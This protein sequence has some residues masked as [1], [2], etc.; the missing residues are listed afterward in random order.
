MQLYLSNSDLT[1]QRKPKG[2]NIVPI[3][4]TVAI[5]V[6]AI[7]QFGPKNN[8][9]TTDNTQ[10]SQAV[11]L[12]KDIELPIPQQD[13]SCTNYTSKTNSTLI[14]VSLNRKWNLIGPEFS[15]EDQQVGF[16][17]SID[18]SITGDSLVLQ[19]IVKEN[20]KSNYLNK[21]DNTNYNGSVNAS[22][23]DPGTY[24]LQ[25]VVMDKC[26]YLESQEYEFYVS[27]PVYVAWTTDWEG[28]PGGNYTYAMGKMENV[29]D[30]YGV[31][32][33]HMFNPRI[34]LPSFS[35]STRDTYVNWV[36]DQRD[37]HGAEI[38]LHLHMFYD[39]VEAAG[40]T[41]RTDPKW[42]DRELNGYNVPATAYTKDEYIKIANWAVDQFEANNLGTPKAYRAG[43][44]YANIET[45]QAV[46]TAGLEIDSS[47]RTE[48]IYRSE[49]ISNY[50][51]IPVVS[52]PYHPSIADPNTDKY[53]K[54]LELWEIPNNGGDSW[55]FPSSALKDRF[56]QNFVNK[57]PQTEHRMVVYVSHPHYS[58][59]EFPK[60]IPVIDYIA[61]YSYTSDNG[62][63]IFATLSEIK[64][65]WKQL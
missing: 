54:K 20:S 38:G 46:Q 30:Q 8:T 32:I 31:K 13:P 36:I 33:T 56:D 65:V 4:L 44:W 3:I 27:K 45:L 29:V 40:V 50:W 58:T 9:P 15:I 43:G 39:L 7:K 55:S 59:T 41:K 25:V 48:Y 53:T 22:T 10:T 5:I 49:G 19:Y 62:P 47:G 21:I 17:T 16:S 51:S 12:D 2:N 34:F 52:T 63:V 11:V 14:N 28:L 37:N 1:R 18:T 23:M 57:E 24:H 60:I 61:G 42:S 6:I 64:E 35:K 26:L